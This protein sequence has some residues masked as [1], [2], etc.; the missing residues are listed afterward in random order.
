MERLGPAESNDVAGHEY[1]VAPRTKRSASGRPVPVKGKEM[2]PF[3][4]HSTACPFTCRSECGGGQATG[5]RP[6][7]RDGRMHEVSWGAATHDVHGPCMSHRP[8]RRRPGCP[9]AWT[10][11][12]FRPISSRIMFSQTASS[13]SECVVLA[14]RL[15]TRDPAH[16]IVCLCVCSERSVS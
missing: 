2:L 4:S 5:L 1:V 16:L 9:C 6:R 12:C 8:R 15:R 10:Y 11:L 13:I 3:L 7:D 14:S